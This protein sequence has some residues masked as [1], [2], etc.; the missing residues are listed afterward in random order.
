LNVAIWF[1][2]T[3]ALY[4]IGAFKLRE[5]WVLL[6]LCGQLGI[7]ALWVAGS[8]VVIKDICESCDM[9]CVECYRSNTVWCTTAVIA[10][11]IALSQW[12]WLY[13]SARFVGKAGSEGHTK[14]N[15][16]E[17]PASL[18]LERAIF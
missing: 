10:T 13:L 6:F 18:N 2:I 4:L 11:L 3:A 9:Q 17:D 15:S 14:K 5:V 1:L 8:Y 7:I 12:I 16:T